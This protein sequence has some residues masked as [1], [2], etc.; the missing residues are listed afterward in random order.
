MIDIVA[1]LALLW[2]YLR[3]YVSVGGEYT[4]FGLGLSSW[5]SVFDVLGA[6]YL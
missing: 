3:R 4:D 2:G 1:V 5:V 6:L